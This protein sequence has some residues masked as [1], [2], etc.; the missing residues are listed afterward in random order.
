MQDEQPPSI[1]RWVVVL[2]WVLA[3]IGLVHLTLTMGMA[4]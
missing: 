2:L 1:L 3:G 4:P